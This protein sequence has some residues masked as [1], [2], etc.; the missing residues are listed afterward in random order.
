MGAQHDN[1]VIKMSGRSTG[2]KSLVLFTNAPHPGAQI[3]P[4]NVHLA[5]KVHN[6]L[7]ALGRIGR[8]AV[9]GYR[10][11]ERCLLRT[12]TRTVIKSTRYLRVSPL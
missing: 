7:A 9:H 3:P 1:N 10:A 8:T 6:T 4:A 2:M 12:L 5:T 11:V